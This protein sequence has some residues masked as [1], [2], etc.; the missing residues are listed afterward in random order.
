M[1]LIEFK[2]HVYPHFQS[3]GFA[4][5]FA[6][7]FAEML[8]VGDGV[9]V[10]CMKP[11]WAFPGAKPVDIAFNDGFH[12]LNLPDNLDYIFSSHCLEHL[13]NYV[14]A[15]EYWHKQLIRIVGQLLRFWNGFEFI[16]LL[17][18]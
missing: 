4:A 16:I 12:A 15:L 14:T 17:C 13:D 1:K 5:Q 7:P 6:F 10:G 18:G 8:C 11:E 3:E 2:N 9:D